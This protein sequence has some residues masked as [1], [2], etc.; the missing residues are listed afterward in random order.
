[1]GE[2]SWSLA[3][4]QDLNQKREKVLNGFFSL[5]LLTSYNIKAPDS[6]T[7]SKAQNTQ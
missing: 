4:E 2:A 1:M 5:K 6:P 3:A 7:Q